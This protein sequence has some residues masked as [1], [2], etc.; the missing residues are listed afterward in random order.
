M[1]REQRIDSCRALMKRKYYSQ[2]FVQH[3]HQVVEEDCEED[4]D[5]NKY[6]AHIDS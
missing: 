2:P 1:I 6:F 5:H 3:Y 4:Q